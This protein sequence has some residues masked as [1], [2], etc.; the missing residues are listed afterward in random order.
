M[1]FH[2]I[3]IHLGA[4]AFKILRVKFI[5]IHPMT[6]A[7]LGSTQILE[8]SSESEGQVSSSEDESSKVVEEEEDKPVFRL[9]LEKLPF[10]LCLYAIR[11]PNCTVIIKENYTFDCDLTFRQFL[12][13][14]MYDRD[15]LSRVIITLLDNEQ[16][17]G[18]EMNFLKQ[19]FLNWFGFPC[20][21]EEFEKF[22]KKARKE[23]K[24]NAKWMK[25]LLCKEHLQDD[26]VT[27]CLKCGAYYEAL[28]I[29]KPPR[30]KAPEEVENRE[31]CDNCNRPVPCRCI[32]CN[33]CNY[34]RCG[35]LKHMIKHRPA[36]CTEDCNPPCNREDGAR[37]HGVWNCSCEFCGECGLLVAECE[38]QEE[39]DSSFD[40]VD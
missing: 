38:C 12:P 36:P 1:T 17:L 5:F 39:S 25:R 29:V 21:K 13:W 4:D 10:E 30:V 6:E 24:T 31:L 26:A 23:S 9:K 15:A 11:E 32:I 33:I 3:S 18:S 27:A 7:V 28:K 40:Y 8:E 34:C 14:I 35:K 16:R 20:E 22:F 2:N 19:V 37:K